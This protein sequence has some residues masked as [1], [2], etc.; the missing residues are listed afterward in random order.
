[1]DAKIKD[2]IISLLKARRFRNWCLIILASVVAYITGKRILKYYGVRPSKKDK[3]DYGISMSENPMKLQDSF[4]LSFPVLKNQQT[5]SSCVA[6][7]LSYVSEYLIPK[8]GNYNLDRVSVGWIYGYRPEGYYKGEGMFPRQAM[9]T[10]QKKGVLR[11][12]DFPYNEEVPEIINRVNGSLPELLKKAEPNKI[13]V[14]FQLKNNDE[15]KQC[16]TKYGPVTIMYP[17]Y[18][19]FNTPNDDK[20]E[21]VKGKFYGYH[22]V[23]LYGWTGNY[24]VMVNSWGDNWDEDGIAK[25]SMSY[26]WQEAWGLSNDPSAAIVPQKKNIFYKMLVW[27]KNWI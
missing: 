26:P 27:I 6:H 18:D 4:S 12:R 17:V 14:F 8:T 7:S 1:M 23:T 22:Q 11:H 16:L 20:I 13:P 2:A 5:V 24:W 3:R 9:S 10:L 15:I 25:I 19:S 21:S